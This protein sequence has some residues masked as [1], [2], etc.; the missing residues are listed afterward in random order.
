[1]SHFSQIFSMYERKLDKFIEW[2]L[3]RRRICRKPSERMFGIPNVWPRFIQFFFPKRVLL[4]NTILSLTSNQNGHTYILTINTVLLIV[5]TKV[6]RLWRS[7]RSQ[8][9]GELFGLMPVNS[10]KC[11]AEP[12]EWKARRGA[13]QISNHPVSQHSEAI[14]ENEANQWTRASTMVAYDDSKLNLRQLTN[15]SGAAVCSLIRCKAQKGTNRCQQLIRLQMES[16]TCERKHR[17][18][19]RITKN[20]DDNPGPRLN[21]RRSHTNTQTHSQRNLSHSLSTLSRKYKSYRH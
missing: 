21:A 17:I 8:I 13:H 19:R 1:M 2:H 15:I 20:N 3:N 9:C 10:T 16:T 7:S 6:N 11:C 12:R 4:L 5:C 18:E 14:E